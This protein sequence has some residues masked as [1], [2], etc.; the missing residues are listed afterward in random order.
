MWS[1]LIFVGWLTN[2]RRP[3]CCNSYEGS[4][5]SS[6]R[7]RGFGRLENVGP[8]ESLGCVPGTEVGNVSVAT[9][10]REGGFSVRRVRTAGRREGGQQ[11]RKRPVSPKR[12]GRAATAGN[13]QNRGVERG[14]ETETDAGRGAC[15]AAQPLSPASVFNVSSHSSAP[16]RARTDRASPRALAPAFVFLQELTYLHCRRS[17]L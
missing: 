5:E 16:S 8:G 7:L 9:K 1:V 17:L 14:K 11:S 3:W 4:L 6:Y 12:S 10:G 2:Y 13:T 15:R